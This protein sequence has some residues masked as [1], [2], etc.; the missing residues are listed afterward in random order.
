WDLS[1]L[2]SVVRSILPLPETHKPHWDGISAEQIEEELLD[3]AG[4]FYAAKEQELGP[5]VVHQLERLLM[6]HI[7][8]SHWVRHLTALDGL[9]EGIG[10]RALAQ[11]DPLVEYKREAFGMFDE[12]KAAISYEVT[13]KFFFTTVLRQ[14]VQRSVRTYGPGM[15][16]QRAAPSRAPAGAR[17]GRND[18]CP[19]GSGRKYK[20]CCMRKDLVAQP[21]GSQ[22]Q[23]MAGQ[24]QGSSRQ[25]MRKKKRR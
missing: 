7:V 5:E 15:E 2:L 21:A 25:H 18:P 23:A 4:Q 19:C 22:P 6:L 10:L 14:P 13:R 9:R 16:G 3:L 12:L 20:N 17:I 8:D 24:S 11:R 1:G